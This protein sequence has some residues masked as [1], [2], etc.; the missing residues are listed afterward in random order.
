MNSTERQAQEQEIRNT[1]GFTGP[2]EKDSLGI[3]I[4]TMYN[5]NSDLI[6]LHIMTILWTIG[7]WSV[8]RGGPW[9][10]QFQPKW[11]ARWVIALILVSDN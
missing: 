1:T 4:I 9:Y 11:F 7:R 2:V 10:A 5:I 3:S 6:Q 8:R